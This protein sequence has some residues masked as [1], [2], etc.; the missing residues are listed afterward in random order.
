MLPPFFNSRIATDR[1]FPIVLV[2]G[3]KYFRHEKQFLKQ[4]Y[5]F[6]GIIVVQIALDVLFYL[7]KYSL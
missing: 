4:F 5:S 7:E 2:S 3:K 1:R 6:P